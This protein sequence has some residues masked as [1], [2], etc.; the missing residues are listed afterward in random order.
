MKARFLKFVA[1][2]IIP[3][4][5][6]SFVISMRVGCWDR[7][8]GLDKVEKV[9][10]NF[11]SSYKPNVSH[12]VRVGDPAWN[13]LMR[14]ISKYSNVDLPKD[15]EPRVLARFV[16]V[17]SGKTDLG[18]GKIAEWTA[19]STPIVVIYRDWPGQNVSTQDYRIVGTISDL[20]TW[21][22]RSKD[23]FRFI[24]QDILLAILSIAFGLL[25]WVSEGGRGN[26]NKQTTR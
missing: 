1:A 16:A 13:P 12:T 18:Q 15:R 24:I 10:E 17:L 25:I 21:I 22:N 5:V 4:I 11:E 26:R 3:L 9:A 14:L 23:D 8:F 20:R 7:F 2:I 6:L 19:P